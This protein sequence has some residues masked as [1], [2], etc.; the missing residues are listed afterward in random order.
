MFGLFSV[1]KTK[2]F[3]CVTIHVVPLHEITEQLTTR[4]VTYAAASSNNLCFSLRMP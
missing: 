1:P 4:L 2:Y 3:L